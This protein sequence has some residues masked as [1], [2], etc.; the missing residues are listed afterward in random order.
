MNEAAILAG[1]IALV[2]GAAGGIGSAVTR[3]LAGAGARVAGLDR[4]RPAA[5]AA[6]VWFEVDATDDEAVAR[7]VARIEREL[8]GLDLVVHATGI[9]R[10]AVLWKLSLEDWDA[11]LRTNLTSAFLLLR[12]AIP[13]LRRR[14][15][16]RIVLL[17]SI[18]AM[19]G[20]LG[21]GAYAASKAGLVGL[22]KTAARETARFGILVNVIEPGMVRTPMTEALDET[23]RR[24]AVA[25]SL[26]GRLADPEDIAQAVVFLC[27]PGARHI[28]GQVLRVDGGQYL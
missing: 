18:N 1:Q 23:V 24:Q 27:S 28:T 19:R 10:D 14:G 12:H 26:L 3:M 13:A 17:G 22:A 2:T 20:K 7:A 21:Q 8:G 11:V 6:E 5:S 9:A 4:R 15:G 25:E 16:G